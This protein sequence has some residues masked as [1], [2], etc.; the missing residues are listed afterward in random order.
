[1]GT[2]FPSPEVEFE[3]PLLNTAGSLGFIPDSRA[4]IHFERFG[5]FVTNPISTRARK[6]ANPPRLLD[7]PG[8]ILLHTGHPNPG[9]S[10]A[11]KAFA[12]SWARSPV[13]V[14]IHLLT[15]KPEDVRKAILRFEELENVLA[16]ELGFEVDSSPVLVGNTVKLAIGE[17]PVI[18]Q[19]PLSRLDLVESAIESGASAISLGPPR[20]TL[21]IPTGK[22][23]SGRLY[24][25][26]IF[27]LALEAVRQ[28]KQMKIKVI[29][30]GGVER[31]AQVEDMLAVGAFAVQMDIGLWKAN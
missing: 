11:I 16:V 4:S 6:P 31:E 8:G 24:G 15:G 1:M 22:Y 3:K 10:G 29:G 5:A 21:P 28:L 25:P 20:G 2:N 17:L 30:A 13:P 7:F 26:S 12:S 9:V 18:A 19:I 23:V 27:P 14:I